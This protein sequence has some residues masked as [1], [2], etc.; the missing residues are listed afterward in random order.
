M[1]T[2]EEIAHFLS[3]G[4]SLEVMCSRLID[5][6]NERGG[7]DNISVVLLKSHRIAPQGS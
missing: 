6:A 7:N 1:L 4:G 5:A 2:D 3:L